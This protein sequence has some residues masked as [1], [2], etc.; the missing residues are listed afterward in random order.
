MEFFYVSN[1]VFDG[2][3][4]NLSRKILTVR[5]TAS[6]CNWAASDSGIS[7][8]VTHSTGRMDLTKPSSQGEVVADDE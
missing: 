8:K 4:D 1:G 5:A 2:H 7:S 3:F 6:S